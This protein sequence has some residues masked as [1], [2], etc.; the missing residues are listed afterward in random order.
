MLA[1]IIPGLVLFALV[2]SIVGEDRLE[3]PDGATWLGTALVY[4]P[5]VVGLVLVLFGR[6]IAAVI[7]PGGIR[8]PLLVAV[9]GAVCLVAGV[10]ALAAG[11]GQG[12][13]NI[14]AGS[15]VLVGPVLMSAGLVIAAVNARRRQGPPTLGVKRPP[16]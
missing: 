15:L 16:A 9:V 1:N 13:A 12:D 10:L 11:S 4:L 2:A 7:P 5:V 6:R 3:G 14:G 8:L